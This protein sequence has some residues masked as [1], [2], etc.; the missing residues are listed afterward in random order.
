[1]DQHYDQ[2][3]TKE[4]EDSFC[5]QMQIKPKQAYQESCETQQ[6]FTP[7]EYKLKYHRRNTKF[8]RARIDTCS[9]TNVMPASIY[10]KIFKDP[11]CSKLTQIQS[12]GIYTYTTEKIP[13]IGSCELLVLH[14]DD[15]C[16]LKVPF[17]VVSIEGS[18]IV[19][20]ATSINLNLIQIHSELDTNVPDC[21]RLYYSSAD[22]PGTNQEQ[23]KKSNLYSKV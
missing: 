11:D 14:P 22:K 10:K 3:D 1:M 20:Y 4:S 9:N 21:A 6:L 19:S 12:E 16:F 7:L 18:V 17:H 5:F 13:V 23:Q 8:L 15:K 2:E